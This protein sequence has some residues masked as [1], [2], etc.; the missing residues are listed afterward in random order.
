M[1][2]PEPGQLNHPDEAK[3]PPSG[4]RVV[5]VMY[6]DRPDARNTTGPEMSVGI[7]EA[8]HRHGEGGAD[9]VLQRGHGVAAERLPCS[10]WG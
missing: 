8:A 2:Q 6:D 10:A 4:W 5:P 1:A 3:V 7:A 9:R